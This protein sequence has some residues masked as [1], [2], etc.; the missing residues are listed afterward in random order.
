MAD[1]AEELELDDDEDPDDDDD[2]EEDDEELEGEAPG[3]TSGGELLEG[4]TS[5][6]VEEELPH[7]S[8]LLEEILRR[9]SY[10]LW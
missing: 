6:A 1:E 9:K 8:W 2:V 5:T 7:C 4:P 3:F 10:G